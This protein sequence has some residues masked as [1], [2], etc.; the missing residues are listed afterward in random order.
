[1]GALACVVALPVHVYRHVVS[2]FLPQTCRFT[3]SC[4]QYMIEALRAH[5]AL[6]GSWLGVKR[7]CR[8]HPWGG[9]GH[10]PVPEGHG[11]QDDEAPIDRE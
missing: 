1:M 9:G 7:V 6:H 3:P 11:L 5:G 4:S 2:P 8:C 10:D